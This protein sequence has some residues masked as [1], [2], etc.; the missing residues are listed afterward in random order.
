MKKRFVMILAAVMSICCVSCGTTDSSESVETVPE[1]SSTAEVSSEE[2][3]S[4]EESAPEDTSSTEEA[5]DDDTDGSV[6]TTADDGTPMAVLNAVWSQYSE[7]DMFPIVGGDYSE[8]NNNPTGAGRYSIDDAEAL[9]SA[10][11]FPAASIDKIEDCASLLH[12]MNANT[13]TAA[14]FR[15]KA[16]VSAD[17]VAEAVAENVRNRQWM[18][19]MPDKFVIYTL[20]QDVVLILGENELAE[21]FNTKLSATYPDA[22]KK[23]DE[24]ITVE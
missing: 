23:V 18:C 17:D 12:A 22:T 6:G 21:T 10:L 24:P 11:V 15:V 3:S 1:Q 7:N 9:D 20:G 4:E 2:E 19:G 13:F 8:E 14:V 16:E 5:P